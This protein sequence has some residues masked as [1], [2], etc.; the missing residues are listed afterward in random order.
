MATQTFVKTTCPRDCYDACGVLVKM[1]ND[2]GISIVGDPDHDMS[3][4]KLCG[5]CSIAYNGVWRSKA[6][7]LSKPMKRVGP[8]GSGA[9]AAVSWDAA[10]GEIAE[11]L[12][13][14]L[15]R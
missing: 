15:E 3:R 8:K 4:G 7:R 9:F 12:R 5:K 10:L 14:I 2:G 11:R 13:G 6:D 1:A